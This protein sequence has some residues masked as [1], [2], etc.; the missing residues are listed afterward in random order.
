MNTDEKLERQLRSIL[1][2]T[3]DRELGPDP[4]WPE[5]PAARRVAELDRRE[6]RRRWPLRVL[7][8]AALIGAGGGAALL[9]GRLTPPPEVTLDAANGW[10]AFTVAQRDPAGEDDDLDIWLVALDRDARRVVGADTDDVD[11][12][13]PAFAPDGRS[14]AY[15]QVQGHSTSG[16]D[17]ERLAAYRNAALVVADVSNDGRVTDRLTVDVGDGLPP[18]CPVWSPDGDQVAFGVPRTSPVNPRTSAA[19]SE[20]WVVTLADR[21]ITVLPDLLAT[22]LEWSPDGSLLAIASGVDERVRGNVLHDGRI[23]L[24]EPS[25]GEMRPLESTL[26]ATSFTWSPDGRR[27]AYATIANATGDSEN[28]LRVVDIDTGEEEL[29]AARYGVM[30]GIGPVWSPDGETIVYQ[31][32]IGSGERHEVVLVMPGE[33]SGETGLPSEVVVPTFQ[34]TT[35]GSGYLY[36]YRVTWSPDGEYLLYLAWGEGMAAPSGLVAVPTDPDMESVVLSLDVNFVPYD[37][38]PDTSLVPIQMWGRQPSD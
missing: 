23:H 8:V 35:R 19:G 17:A 4:A 11:Q 20:V 36:P 7:A 27:I 33:M 38:Y 29:L 21:D 22:D 37:G 15:G 26:G 34:N 3:L 31:R 32:T 18:P 12:L 16:D 2:E 28:E 5:S 24:Y 1:R 6:R 10:I 25:S 9:G 30:H 13:C 14:L